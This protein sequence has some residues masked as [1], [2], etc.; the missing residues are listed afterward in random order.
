M[1]FKVFLSFELSVAFEHNI[2]HAKLKT[3]QSINRELQQKGEIRI[4][5]YESFSNMR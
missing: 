5:K 2:R 3:M 4:S 1:K